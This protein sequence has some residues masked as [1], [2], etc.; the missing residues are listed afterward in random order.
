MKSVLSFIA[1]LLIIW[2]PAQAFEDL[3]V[4]E[5]RIDIDRDDITVR[6]KIDGASVVVGKGDYKA[7]CYFRVSYAKERCEANVRFDEER[8]ELRIEVDIE[9]ISFFKNN[10]DGDYAGV[11][12]GLP[13]DKKVHLYAD[14]KAGEIDFELGDLNIRN[15]QLDNWAGE[16][17]VGFD[18]PNR[19]RME[20]FDVSVRMGEMTLQTLGN[21]RFEQA[22][23]NGGVGELVVDFTGLRIERAMARID[24]DVGETNLVLPSDIGIKLKVSKFLFLSSIDYPD[25]FR[26]RGTYFYSKNYTESE[27]SL[28]LIISS[29]IGELNIDMR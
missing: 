26:K 21:A 27:D 7:A 5:D 15:F 16:V 29:G 2:S 25:W 12:L 6:L 19:S 10:S 4:L 11:Y 17:T 14:V 1:L 20:L 13:R 3:V 18:E 28:Y 23:I 9:N 24:L 8:S 22:D